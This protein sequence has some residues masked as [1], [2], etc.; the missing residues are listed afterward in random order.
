V[1]TVPAGPADLIYLCFPNNPTGAVATKAQ[2]A[3]WVAYAKANAGDHP[4][5]SA[6]ESYIR[7]PQIPRSIYEIEG[8]RD[9]AI[10]FRSF[11]K[12]AGFTGL[13]CAYTVVPK[14][15][16]GG[17]LPAANIPSMRSGTAATQPNSTAWPTPFSGPPRRSTPRPAGSSARA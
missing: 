12:L 8:A 2:L 11:S 10:E 7:D 1:P 15:L 13:R 4:L 9:V 3:A 5:D 6:Y 14:S 17:T 16:K